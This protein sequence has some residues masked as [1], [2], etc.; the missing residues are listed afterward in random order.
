MRDTLKLPKVGDAVDKV[1]VIDAL[2][3]VGE[4]FAVGQSVLLVETDKA[5]LE[6]PPPFAGPMIE[7]FIS[8]SKEM[9]TGTRTLAIEA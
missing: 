9:A 1:V 6:I 5:K 3:K 2:A 7:I 4:W 8:V